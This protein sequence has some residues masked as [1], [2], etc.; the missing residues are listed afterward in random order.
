[1]R[2]F[3]M[4]M[5]V[6]AALIGALPAGAQDRS[7]TVMATTTILADVARNVAG[8]LL[9]VESL[10]PPAADTHAYEPTTADA[11]R[12][13]RADLLLT[14][15]LGY[16]TFIER[17]LENVGGG[18][19]AVSVSNGIAVLPLGEHA[20]DHEDEMA[21]GEADHEHHHG[22]EPIGIAGEDDLACDAHD[23]DHADH[24]HADHDHGVCDP[25]VWMNPL[26]VAIWTNNI[27]EAFAELDPAHADAYRANAAEYVD[28]LT[29]LDAE[30]E[31]MVDEHLPDEA[32]RV[33]ITNH[34]FLGYFA[35]RYH[36]EVAATVLPGGSTA[37]GE[38]D[39][40]TLA[41]LIERV[42]TEGV[43]AIFA[44]VSA[45]PRVAELVAQES[46]VA[47]VTSLYSESLSDSG[48]PAATYLDFMRYNAWTIVSSLSER[49]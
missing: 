44:E 19:P 17:L 3:L 13:A 42:R 12:L 33:L 5:M 43:P 10:L 32:G 48:G 40:Q 21:E 38:V 35:A 27:A 7:L 49:G 46:G 30:I 39:T 15:G 45:N 20:H 4:I 2:R 23:D 41:A 8:D 11:A 14:I 25:H 22:P 16:E 9:T 24:D 47:V 26:H 37:A 34:E 31:A 36:F 1:M 28:R 29:A 18:I 6:C